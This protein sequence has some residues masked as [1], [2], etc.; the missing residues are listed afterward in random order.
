MLPFPF[1]ESF[2]AM[3]PLVVLGDEVLAKSRAPSGDF[4]LQT[5]AGVRHELG[6]IGSLRSLWKNALHRLLPAVTTMLQREIP[7]RVAELG[8]SPLA[9]FI[10]YLEPTFRERDFSEAWYLSL[11]PVKPAKA[12]DWTVEVAR[13]GRNIPAPD[14]VS[15]SVW[16]LGRVWKLREQPARAG[17]W[18][19]ITPRRCYG[20]SGDFLTVGTVASTWRGELSKYVGQVAGRI[21]SQVRSDEVS[22]S[23]LDAASRE[24]TTQGYV[25]RG[26]L[27]FLPCSPPRLGHLVPPHY[28]RT[29]GRQVNRDLAMTAPLILPLPSPPCRSKLSVYERRPGGWSPASLPHGLCLGPDPPSH[30][31]E[32][33]GV[34]LAAL[35]RWAAQ[36]IAEN[37]AFHSSDDAGTTAEYA[38]GY[39]Y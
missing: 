21:A 37:G 35:L 34:G 7:R 29:L 17:C 31:Q 27:L 30:A 15:P 28:N 19:V 1:G 18:Q 23:G 20:L 4:L 38:E 16:I 12:V 33:P 26:D 3:Q 2:Q 8:M 22:L 24:I 25:E 11:P 6:P 39:N 13:A 14:L 9:Y 10:D 36:R 32:S 5:A